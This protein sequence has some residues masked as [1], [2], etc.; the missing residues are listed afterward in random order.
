MIALSWAK[1]L[2][3][4][5]YRLLMGSLLV[6]V[7]ACCIK[8][9]QRTRMAERGYFRIEA[10]GNLEKLPGKFWRGFVRENG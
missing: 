6:L 8:L 10:P 2:K 7:A 3:T 4:N 9:R 1:P 5:N